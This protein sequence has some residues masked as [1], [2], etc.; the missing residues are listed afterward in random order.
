MRIKSWKWRHAA[1]TN[2][3]DE[4]TF[5]V[6]QS[7]ATAIKFPLRPGDVLSIGSH[8]LS[9]DIVDDIQVESSA[10]G[11]V[12]AVESQY[13]H[14]NGQP[15]ILGH[16]NSILAGTST[17]PSHSANGITIDETPIKGSK[18]KAAADVSKGGLAKDAIQGNEDNQTWPHIV[19]SSEVPGITSEEGR[20]SQP[21]QSWPLSVPEKKGKLEVE[22]MG[23]TDP[24]FRRSP[25]PEGSHRVKISDSQVD[26]AA[27]PIHTIGEA[28]DET[29]DDDS[30][31]EDTQTRNTNS[32]VRLL[33]AGSLNERSLNSVG[34]PTPAGEAPPTA[35][36]NPADSIADRADT[37]DATSHY[38]WKGSKKAKTTAPG[39][40]E[41]QDSMRSA[42]VLKQRTATR[43][44]PFA[45]S[46]TETTTPARQRSPAKIP[47]TAKKSSTACVTTESMPSF[48]STNS[49]GRE[50]SD[51]P[52]SSFRSTRSAARASLDSPQSPTTVTK[53]VFASSATVDRSKP[54]MKFLTSQ[55][56]R[57]VEDVADA[58]I[59]CVGKDAEL[60]RTSNLI[61][62]VAC[63]KHI[64]TD[65][66]VVDSAKQGKLL[67][68]KDYE[69]EDPEREQEW[70]TTLS[71]AVKRGR[72]GV[73]V[74][75][76][77][78]IHLTP[79]AKAKLGKGFSELKQICLQA[80]A[81]SVQATTPKKGPQ[82]LPRTLV[83]AI[84]ADK[85]LELLRANG[86]HSYSKEIITY[87]VLRGSLD[88]SSD[89]FSIGQPKAK[90]PKATS[91][92]R[93]R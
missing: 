39:R 43:T 8:T 35:A 16:E 31:Q 27:G 49:S 23:L 46:P 81:N 93:K 30:V 57:Q 3:S 47:R 74:L 28:H 56:I 7:Y 44:S 4:L 75:N 58:D 2:D 32:A 11:N 92:K 36:V 90:P 38:L 78:T 53:V 50:E 17:P 66:W 5:L 48:R 51:G 79:N 34:S 72:K 22:P 69:A 64:V 87:S 91:K 67:D 15:S 63:G 68:A 65:N 37:E 9:V 55:G 26:A 59:L 1:D 25:S 10:V 40:E 14:S 24:H 41:S 89:E 88:L 45:R 42:V 85:D 13:L 60:K 86:W 6:P 54:L 82:E 18:I 62:A 19:A 84:E 29:T 61:T 80:G 52:T 77:W 12:D 73:R 21:D 20:R 76:D 70:G 71:D 83:I 33:D